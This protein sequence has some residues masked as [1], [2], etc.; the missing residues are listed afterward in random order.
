MTRIVNCASL[1]TRVHSAATFVCHI[2]QEFVSPYRISLSSSSF[3]FTRY[4]KEKMTVIKIKY[5]DDKNSTITFDWDTLIGRT[6]G[7]KILIV[8]SSHS[9]DFLPILL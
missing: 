1:V 9:G 8:S 4:M 6:S 5:S 7:S 2:I 3:C